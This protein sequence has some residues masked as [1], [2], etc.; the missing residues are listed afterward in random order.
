MIATIP[1]V[2]QIRYIEGTA[3]RLTE[4]A[5]I[6]LRMEQPEP[7]IVDAVQLLFPGHPVDCAPPEGAAGYT[8]HIGGEAGVRP[9]DH[10]QG[11]A[12]R[13]ADSAVTIAAAQAVGLFYGLHTLRQLL[14]SGE[15]LPAAEIADW[16]DTDMRSMHFDLR[17]THSKPELLAQYM[18]EFAKWKINAV[19]IEYEDRFPFER[20]EELRHPEHAFSREQFEAL[21]AAAR[22]H[23]IEIIPLQQSFGHLEYVLRHDSYKQLR[24]TAS[25]IGEICPSKPDSF[26]LVAGMLA[27]VMEMHPDSRYIHLGC[28]EVYSLCECD[29][30][31]ARF[32]GSK[33]KAFVHFVNRL[34]DYCAVRG[35]RPILWHD[36]LEKCTPAELSELDRRAVVMIWIYNGRNIEAT[37]AAIAAKY[38][39]LGIEVMGA[40]AVRCYDDREQQNVPVIVNR[41]DNLLQWAE[42]AE[43]LDIRGCIATNW[44]GAF[45]LGVPYGIFETTWYL[46]GLHADLI[47]NRKGDCSRYIDKFLQ[48]FHG[49]A[50]DAAKRKLGRFLN[51]DYYDVIWKLSGDVRT[52][53][54]IAA[55][56]AVMQ[57]FEAVTDKTRT[58]H[59]SMYRWDLMPRDEAERRSLQNIYD[60]NTAG[61]RRVRPLM[62]DLLRRYQSEQ[63]AEHYVVS[64]FYIHD[65]LEATKYREMGLTESGE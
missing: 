13:M 20:Y 60:R 61:M 16:P 64:R 46:M 37:V 30:C 43:K 52:N 33:G 21:I 19:L 63:M 31:R 50:P 17:L 24:E 1:Q 26:R 53:K 48:L 65:W 35:K 22:R 18:G 15:A 27:E 6:L 25:S 32:A 12:I 56:I 38:R 42:T 51:E 41:I 7:R 28:D 57:E 34:I 45:T 5:V 59:K 3:F 44:A 39:A 11:Y 54:D 47:W 8:F 14:E 2:K 10:P 58:I 49:I 40:P 4:G 62:S 55:L 36:M 9:H 29:V 23:F